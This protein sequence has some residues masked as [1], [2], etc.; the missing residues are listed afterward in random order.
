MVIILQEGICDCCELNTDHSPWC[1][2]IQL[3]KLMYHG[4]E[5][6]NNLTQLFS[7]SDLSWS[8]VS[9]FLHYTSKKKDRVQL[10]I[11]TES[12]GIDQESRKCEL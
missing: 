12:S 9:T 7:A 6:R 11:P 8:D 4:D 1:E 2:E 10:E 3:Y 5:M